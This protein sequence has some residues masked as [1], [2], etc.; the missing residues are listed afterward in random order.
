MDI[1]NYITKRKRD[2]DSESQTESDNLSASANEY[3]VNSYKIC[4]DGKEYF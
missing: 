1:R 3:F 2:E 4:S